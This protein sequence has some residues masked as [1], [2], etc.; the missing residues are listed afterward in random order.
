MKQQQ[1]KMTS[2][3]GNM[4][5]ILREVGMLNEDNELDFNTQKKTMEKLNFEDDWFK[6]R[7][8]NDIETCNK[9][10]DALP[11]E[12]QN[13][14]VFPGLANIPKVQAFMRCTKYAK[15][16]SCMY[17][18]VKARVETNFGPLDKILEQTKLTEDEL[19]PLVISLYHEDDVDFAGF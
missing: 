10:A 18:D 5:C 2:E 14:F 12:V 11:S 16:K 17:K 13:E 19:F 8:F 6:N 4:T 3:V 1:D 9:V 7:I 15:A